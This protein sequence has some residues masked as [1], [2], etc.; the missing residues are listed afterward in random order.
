MLILSLGL[1]AL[2]AAMLGFFIAKSRLAL[3][4]PNS[5]SMHTAPTPRLGGVALWLGFGCGLALQAI[6]LQQGLLLGALALVV[7]VSLLDDIHTLPPWPRLAAQL[8][9]ALL[10]LLGTDLIPASLTIPG[11]AW[12]WP[13]A[14]ALPLCLVFLVWTSNCFNF[15]DGLD[16][17]AATQAITGFTALAIMAGASGAPWLMVATSLTAAGALG[18]LPWNW[19]PARLF[20]GDGGA[21]GL[22]FWQGTLTLYGAAQGVFPLW[23]GLLGFAPFLLDGT[24]TLLL[25]TLAGH[26]PLVPHRDHLYQRLALGA[27]GV[28]RTLLVHGLFMLCC[29][30]GACLTYQQPLPWGLAACLTACGIHLVLRWHLGTQEASC[31]QSP[32]GKNDPQL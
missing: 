3:D 19:P 5:R 25:R 31:R 9:A 2:V 29:A 12:G 13:H 14:L 26:S 22:G 18:F 10:A 15:M 11:L 7:L 27:W 20:L 24:I 30:A 1:A 32:P 16:G 4:Q 21:V 23:A 28:H 8:G 6:Q 17:L